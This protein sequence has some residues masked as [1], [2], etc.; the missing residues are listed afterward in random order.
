MP[1]EAQDL[2]V[3]PVLQVTSALGFSNSGIRAV[4]PSDSAAALIWHWA[5][6]LVAPS[7]CCWSSP[8][9]SSMYVC[10]L[11]MLFVKQASPALQALRASREPQA[12]QASP[13]LPSGLRTC[14]A[15]P[16]E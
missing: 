12:S 6:V 3:R 7:G 8:T 10:S 13:H 15:V 4:R 14:P 16:P 2:L 1:L 5:C 9:H 11:G